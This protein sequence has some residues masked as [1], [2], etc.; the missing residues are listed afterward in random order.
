MV[1]KRLLHGAPPR[2]CGAFQLVIPCLM[3]H[4]RHLLNY[5]DHVYSEMRHD[6]G[7]G[8]REVGAARMAVSASKKRATRARRPRTSLDGLAELMRSRTIAAA[9]AAIQAKNGV[10]ELTVAEVID[11]A[12]VSRKTFYEIFDDAEDCFVAVFDRTLAHV[13]E[14]TRSAYRGER[15]WRRG[16]RAAL[17]AALAFMDEKR[18]LARVLV[19]DA[20]RAGPRSLERRTQALD[21]IARAIDDARTVGGA[22]HDPPALTAAALAGGIASLLHTRLLRDDPA[23]LTDLQR[24]LMSMI[25]LPY[26]GAS[27]AR[28]ELEAPLPRGAGNGRPALPAQPLDTLNEVDMRLTYR[29]VRVLSAVAGRPEAMN[30]QIAVDAGIADQGQISKLLARLARLGIVENLRPGHHGRGENAWRLTGL[31]E[32][33]ERQMRAHR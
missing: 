4:L 28:K 20:F 31:G 7:S 32:R 14:I 3:T 29:T 1:G 26:L 18:P 23:P 8:S 33:L 17:M 25:V 2:V 13:R 5:T 19:V 22:R 10:G 21:E 16:M 12:R 27:A 9:A 30:W 24:P 15:N 11:R 6:C